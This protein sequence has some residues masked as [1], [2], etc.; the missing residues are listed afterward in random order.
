MGFQI[1]ASCSV[2]SGKILVNGEEVFALQT[3]EVGDFLSQAFKNLGQAYPKFYKMDRL[4]QLGV[5]GTEYLLRE[6]KFDF[7][8]E[9]VS[10]YFVCGNSSLDSDSRHQRLIAQGA[11]V[12]PAVFVYTLPNIVLGEVAIKNKWY[13]ENLLILEPS[14]DK[15]NWL[16]EAKRIIASGKA[17]YCLG[18]WIDAFE[19]KIQLEIYMVG[20]EPDHN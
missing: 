7:G 15:Q 20:L 14:F 1:L 8:D 5:L 4:C 19:E 3:A 9:D 13:G 10:L 11:H 17:K 18:G 2:F 12:S 6:V 16:N